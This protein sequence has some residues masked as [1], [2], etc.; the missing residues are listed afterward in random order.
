MSPDPVVPMF[1]P[2]QHPRVPTLTLVLLGRVGAWGGLTVRGKLSHSM[3]VCGSVLPD[4]GGCVCVRSS[5]GL[6]SPRGCGT[7]PGAGRE[8]WQAG[9][10]PPPPGW[11]KAVG[12]RCVPGTA[13]WPG[14]SSCCCSAVPLP[15]WLQVPGGGGRGGVPGV[16]WGL[17]TP[18]TGEGGAACFPVVPGGGSVAFHRPPLQHRVVGWGVSVC[19]PMPCTDGVSV[20]WGH[21]A[22]GG[23][24]GGH[25]EGGSCPTQ[26][27]PGGCSGAGSSPTWG[28]RGRVARG[29]AAHTPQGSQGGHWGLNPQGFTRLEA[30]TLLLPA[31]G[32]A[33][34]QDT[35]PVLP[36]RLGR[37][38]LAVAWV[39]RH[40]LGILGAKGLGTLC[41][42]R[43]SCTVFP[44]FPAWVLS[45]PHPAPQSASAHLSWHGSWHPTLGAWPWVHRHPGIRWQLGGNG[46]PEGPAGCGDPQHPATRR[47]PWV[48][49]LGA[50]CAVWYFAPVSPSG[51]RLDLLLLLCKQDSG[52]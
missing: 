3:S 43:P 35:T 13:A 10:P 26:P 34:G 9:S 22:L 45:S 20:L 1:P 18:S 27:G 36:N 31:A 11:I 32:S 25:G 21:R 47:S 29:W 49:A 41:G 24:G 30:S 7:A 5:P 4:Q 51:A 19:S 16:T 39:L 23:R 50:G 8:C 52:G 12:G 38:A 28:S 33:V 14:A 15:C 44:L 2:P 48:L 37:L 40:R 17:C 6:Q 42:W 46:F